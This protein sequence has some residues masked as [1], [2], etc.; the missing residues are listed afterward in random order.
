MSLIIP[1]DVQERVNALLGT[2][3]F[4]SEAEILRA[5]ITVLEEQHAD[6]AAIQG[7]INDV[8]NGHYRPFA[9]FDAE[10]RAQ[11]NIENKA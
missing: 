1:S 7:G 4:T 2:G 6:Q 10:F 9:Y 3:R 8:E 11:N 5:A